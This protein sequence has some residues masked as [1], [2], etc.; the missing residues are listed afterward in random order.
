M[1]VYIGQ[2]KLI[3][4]QKKYRII[5]FM[6]TTK[7]LFV[8]INKELKRFNDSLMSWKYNIMV[9]INYFMT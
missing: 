8:G 3:T 6:C 5:N 9:K 4:Q 1:T 2:K 7:I